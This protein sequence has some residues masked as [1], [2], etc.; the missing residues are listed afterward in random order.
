ME[1]QKIYFHRFLETAFDNGNYATD[2]VIAFVLPLFQE[3]LSFHEARLVG[4]FKNEHTLFI[5]DDRLDIDEAFAH[6]PV[7][8]KSKLDNMFLAFK[9][10]NF[11]IIGKT[12][13]EADV[14]EGSYNVENLQV[15][16]NS[17]EPLLYPAFIKGYK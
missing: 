2:D 8:A 14:D 3:V 7:Y 17:N 16:F 11:D 12:K 1:T 15:H 9:S 5:T 13:M 6:A 4:S 10:Q